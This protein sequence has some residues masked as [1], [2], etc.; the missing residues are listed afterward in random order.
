MQRKPLDQIF[1]FFHDWPFLGRFWAKFW[2]FRKFGPKSTQK[3]PIVKKIKR[4]KKRFSLHPL[5]LAA[6]QF[7]DKLT[8]EAESYQIFKIFLIPDPENIDFLQFHPFP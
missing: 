3:S 1:D 8:K 4:L 6:C 5:G 2:N 7:S